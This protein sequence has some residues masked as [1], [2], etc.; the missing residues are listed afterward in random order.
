MK[1]Q[2]WGQMSP[3][4][5]LTNDSF[6]MSHFHYSDYETVNLKF[7]FL[8]FEPVGYEVS[9]LI[10]KKHFCP[11][12][13]N[14][15]IKSLDKSILMLHIKILKFWNNLIKITV[16]VKALTNPIH[17]FPDLR[18]FLSNSVL[19]HKFLFLF[20]PFQTLKNFNLRSPTR[21]D[22]FPKPYC[23]F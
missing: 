1:L 4:L 20:G 6:G 15:F 8:I 22:L 2:T 9:L 7:H 18:F 3:M 21:S 10:N 13:Y 17:L 12:I 19:S 11:K 5:R 14:F 16:K 23:I